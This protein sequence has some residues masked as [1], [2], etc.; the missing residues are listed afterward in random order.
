[1]LVIALD[2]LRA[3]LHRKLLIAL[4]LIVLIVSLIFFM[5][6]SAVSI[7]AQQ[8]G[9]LATVLSI[10]YAIS[11]F[12]GTLTAIY[13]GASA[14]H[15]EISRG[16]IAMVL[17]RPVSRWQF[18]LG[19]YLGAISVLLGYSLIMGGLMLLYTLM[20]DLEVVPAMRY[21]PWLSFCQFLM[22]GSLALL[23]STVMHPALAGVLAFFS[24]LGWMF[25]FFVTEGPF[26]Y[27]SY[28]LPSYSV[29]NV[30]IQFVGTAS[31]YSWGGLA[32]L[33]LYAFDLALIFVLLAMWRLRY[34]E[35]D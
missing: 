16:T 2:F 28:V 18:L 13:V 34:K 10:F 3:L 27:I 25:E 14:I 1:M 19:K 23:L 4:L 22:M 24:D 21:A 12:C 26:F 8:P 7:D 20:Y 17:A 5:V 15:S 33:T 35:V 32:I 31:V 30:W 6:F 9:E 29:F 11:S